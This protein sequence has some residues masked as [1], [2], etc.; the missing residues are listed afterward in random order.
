M[1]E[2]WNDRFSTTEYVYGEKP[3]VFF[4]EKLDIM[5]PGRLLLPAEGEGRNGVYAAQRGWEV[6][7]FDISEQARIKAIA[8]AQKHGV[9]LD[10]R[11]GSLDSQDFEQESFDCLALIYAHFHSEVRN[12]YHK[13][14]ASTLKMGG[15]IIMECFSKAHLEFNSQNPSV[16]GPRDIELLYS[17]DDIRNDFPGFEPI[18]FAVETVHLHEGTYHVGKASVLRYVGRKML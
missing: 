16:G 11:T 9:Q 13:A 8:L 12:Q 10:Y 3:N 1:K 7:A 5:P 18:Q 6:V 17:I 14:L 2:F 4:R 15:L